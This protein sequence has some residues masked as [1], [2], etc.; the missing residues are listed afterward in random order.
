MSHTAKILVHLA[1]LLERTKC[2]IDSTAFLNVSNEAKGLLKA[3]SAPWFLEP[4]TDL[5]LL[6]LLRMVIINLNHPF[7]S[8]RCWNVHIWLNLRVR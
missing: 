8:G 4:N 7:V 1:L 2:F 3:H 5:L 6:L